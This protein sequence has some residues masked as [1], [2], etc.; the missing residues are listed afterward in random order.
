M[1]IKKILVPY[2]D[3]KSSKNALHHAIY[4]AQACQAGLGILSVIDL[5][6]YVS[7]FEQVSTGGYVPAELKENSYKIL[8]EAA[9]EIPKEIK[10]EILVEIGAPP[11]MI[12][13]VCANGAYDA[14]VMGS[15]GLGIIKQIAVGSVSQYVLH[16]AVCP[17]TIVR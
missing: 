16:H 17:V 2:V 3:V 1:P 10:V 7:A 11:A 6:H 14:I 12:I 13:D 9:R 8:V 5:N 4:L 15:R